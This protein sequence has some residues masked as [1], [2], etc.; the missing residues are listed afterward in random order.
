ME[1]MITPSGLLLR[2]TSLMISRFVSHSSI[3]CS[4]KAPRRSARILI[5]TLDSSPEIYNTLCPAVDKLWQT[6]NNS[7]DLPI[8]GSPPTSVRDPCTMPPPSTRSSS[9]IPVRVLFSSRIAISDSTQGS[10]ASLLSLFAP[11]PVFFNSV[12][13]IVSSTKVFHS[14]QPGHCPSHFVDS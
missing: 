7:V 5:C 2:I 6:C 13:S 14:L 11:F 1:S 10:E 4:E 8:P 12:L 9:L 3:I